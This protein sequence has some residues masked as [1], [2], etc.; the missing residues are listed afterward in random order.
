MIDEIIASLQPKEEKPI[1]YGDYQAR[2]NNL[3]MY[4]KWHFDNVIHTNQKKFIVTDYNKQVINLL[5][6][7]FSEHPYFLKPENKTRSKAE[8]YNFD[9]SI[10]LIGPIGCGKTDIMTAIMKSIV[11]LTEHPEVSSNERKFWKAKQFSIDFCSEFDE[12]FSIEGYEMMKKFKAY[13]NFL[14]DDLG[15]D[16]GSSNYS[17]KD[18]IIAGRIMVNRYNL[19]KFVDCKTHYTTNLFLESKDSLITTIESKYGSRE[20]DRFF[21][22]H[23]LIYFPNNSP[24]LRNKI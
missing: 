10:L 24:S 23:N 14:L 19:S 2:F 8:D 5:L 21:E 20:K 1:D 4:V 11:I 12:R 13:K 3:S 7:Y 17:N 18:V 15:H 22:T 6:S 9:K 16:D